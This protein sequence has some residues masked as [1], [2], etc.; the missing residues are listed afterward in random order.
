[1]ADEKTTIDRDAIIREFAAAAKERGL[2][3]GGPPLAD[4]EFHRVPVE[5]DAPGKTSGSYRLTLDGRVNGSI[6]NFKTRRGG[7]W[8]PRQA[9]PA[10]D[11][12]KPASRKRTAPARG[13]PAADAEIAATAGIADKPA[14]AA[15]YTLK[16]LEDPERRKAIATDIAASSGRPHEEV[17]ANLRALVEKDNSPEAAALNAAREAFWQ[18]WNRGGQVTSTVATG[19][20]PV[21]GAAPLDEQIGR[22]FRE[23][24]QS[25]AA[26]T[27]L[28]GS[29]VT[30]TLALD[31]KVETLHRDAWRRTGNAAAGDRAVGEAIR[32]GSGFVAEGLPP[33]AGAAVAKIRKQFQLEQPLEAEVGV[34]T[35]PAVEHVGPS[36]GATQNVTSGDTEISPSS[37]EADHRADIAAAQEAD[38]AGGSD[39]EPQASSNW[40]DSQMGFWRAVAD[41]RGLTARIEREFAQG[42]TAKE[43]ER[44]L[45]SELAFLESAADRSE[46]VLY[47]RQSL[48]IPSRLSSEGQEEFEH[49]KQAYDRRQAAGEEPEIGGA[50]ELPAADLNKGHVEPQVVE[51]GQMPAAWTQP[52]DIESY[53]FA[54]TVELFD[55]LDLDSTLPVPLSTSLDTVAM[56]IR[57]SARM[58]SD[59]PDGAS[60]QIVD[61]LEWVSQNPDPAVQDAAARVAQALGRYDDRD[62]GRAENPFQNPVLAD[63]YHVGRTRTVVEHDPAIGPANA[64]SAERFAPMFRALGVTVDA[65][66]PL[67]EMVGTVD[68]ALRNTVAR[69]VKI[70]DHVRE[71]TIAWVK[72]ASAHAVT[73]AMRQSVENV[74]RT[75]GHYDGARKIVDQPFVNTTVAAAHVSGW[76]LGKQAIEQPARAPKQTVGDT[77]VHGSTVKVGKPANEGDA[78][79]PANDPVRPSG[80]RIADAALARVGQ[81]RVADSAA[82]REQLSAA[83]AR[84]QT[85]STEAQRKVE[86]VNEQLQSKPAKVK[87]TVTSTPGETAKPQTASKPDATP[88]VIEIGDGVDRKPVLKA[89]GYDVPADIA[90]RYVVKDGKFW[91]PDLKNPGAPEQTKPHF[92]DKG[93]RLTSHANDRETIADMISV[94]VVKNFTSIAVTGSATFRRNAW[95]EASLAGVE[96]TNFKPSEAD[97]A[98]LEAATRER[99][100]QREALTIRKGQSPDGGGEPAVAKPTAAANS[101]APAPT[102]QPPLPPAKTDPQPATQPSATATV[103]VTPSAESTPAAVQAPPQTVAELRGLAEKALA[104]YPART[105]AEVMNRFNARMQ[106]AIEIQQRV[107]RGELTPQQALEAIDARF[108]TQK[109]EWTAPAPTPAPATPAPSPKMGV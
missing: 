107:E 67:S 15:Q 60:E 54:G 80:D 95:L 38:V 1:M 85:V 10:A 34:S 106:S 68:D 91:K 71:Q 50:A 14:G 82:V 83:Q 70:P 6:R 9:A 56:R 65:Q 39:P 52:R 57:M 27:N 35:A 25:I 41:R 17:E 93:P 97:R 73:D 44:A 76:T 74:A 8:L 26:S 40:M 104:S 61:W 16:D 62:A 63:A 31:A 20:V 88:N 99:D 19:A 29:E 24:L 101:S 100:R 109:A 84:Q 13:A 5:G 3:L 2:V 47:V 28:K 43:V 78:K 66:R 32:T 49:W 103:A 59:L 42:K 75:L 72:W 87:P 23:A 69:G 81:S 48:G 55:S 90:A 7:N 94:A 77:P 11:P 53:P 102:T 12:E 86:Q 58:N 46:L 30:T 89:S 18:K 92:E 22:A 45:D 79:H 98:L 33:L 64:A 108:K 21:A 36:N 4:G 96:V 37:T 51:P 105:R